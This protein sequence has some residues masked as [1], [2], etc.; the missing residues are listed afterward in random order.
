MCQ[1]LRYVDMLRH[2]PH[3]NWLTGTLTHQQLI[4]V[5]DF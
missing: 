1:L 2:I 3:G 5:F 4:K